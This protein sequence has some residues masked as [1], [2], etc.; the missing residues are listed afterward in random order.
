[1]VSRVSELR[2]KEVINI[3]DGR[4]FGYVGDVEVDLDS[5]RVLALVVPGR[6]RLWGRDEDAIFPWESVRR[7]GTDT[8]LVEA[9]QQY[10]GQ[11]R[12]T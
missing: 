11:K 1:M 12:E 9:G 8:I 7:F 10:P 5:G 2:C 4:R 6:P 3:A